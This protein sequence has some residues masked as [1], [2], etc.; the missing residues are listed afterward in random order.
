LHCLVLILGL[1][2]SPSH[3]DRVQQRIRSIINMSFSGASSL[4]LKHA[5]Y[6]VSKGM[7]DYVYVSSAY[8]ITMLLYCFRFVVL[9]TVA[10]AGDDETYSCQVTPA[11]SP[12]IIVAS[13]T[14]QSNMPLSG[15]NYGGEELLS[16]LL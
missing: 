7:K 10:A 13:A 16:L 14:S 11:E 12:H 1:N 6:A 8:F 5:L 3:S 15:S 2:E 4:A 9:L